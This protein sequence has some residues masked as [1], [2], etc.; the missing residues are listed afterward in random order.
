M[1]SLGPAGDS[2]TNKKLNSIS[3]FCLLQFPSHPVST[4]GGGIK[5][6]GTSFC[7]VLKWDSM[8]DKEN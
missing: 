2:M 1:E 3:V 4:A 6:G 7:I 5:G 8:T